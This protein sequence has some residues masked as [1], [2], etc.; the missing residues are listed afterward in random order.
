M[1][2]KRRT[3]RCC[4]VLPTWMLIFGAVWPAS[5]R[6]V[7][8]AGEID[9]F[10]TPPGHTAM[11][12]PAAVAVDSAGTVFVADGANDRVVVFN[13]AGQYI[14]EIRKVDEESLSR[15]VGIK[16]DPA[17]RLWI[18]DTGHGRVLVRGTDGRL[19]RLI[20]VPPADGGSL[21]DPTDVLP[22]PDDG[23][24]WVV[25]NDGHRLIYLDREGRH[26]AVVGE[27][28]EM[29]GRFH[30]P[31]MIELSQS[32]D[33][34][35]TE[36]LNSR[37]CVLNNKGQVVNVIGTY[38]ISIG[39]L[40]R[41]KG[42]ACD[43]QD[44]VWISDNLLG[45]VQ[46]FATDGRLIDVLRDS[47]GQP[48]PF[49]T[50]A[51]LAFD[52]LGRLYVVEV[53]PG[54]VRRLQIIEQD[55][56]GT[57]PTPPEP[58]FVPEQPRSC[59]VCHIE[60]LQP[61]APGSATALIKPSPDEAVEPVAGR[62]VMCLSC[63]DG[64]VADS[65]RLVWQEH[66]HRPGVEPPASMKVPA[67]LPL[68]NGRI[69]CRTCHSAHPAGQTDDMATA[70]SLRRAGA[71]NELCGACHIEKTGGPSAGVHPVQGMPWA[72]PEELLEP[73]ARQGPSPRDL[74]CRVCHMAHGSREDHLLVPGADTGQLCLNC[75]AKMRPGLWRSDTPREHPQA[76]PLSNDSQRQAIAAMGGR[77]GADGTITC[78]S[79][80]K[81]HDGVTD[82]YLLADSLTDSRLC[83]RCHPEQERMANSAH[84]LRQSAPSER[85][86]LGQTPAQ[87]GPCGPCH[88]IHQYA[89]RPDPQPA[90]PSGTCTT[91]HQ[92]GRCAEKVTRFPFGHP[93]ELTAD[94]D[95][96]G[97]LFT[98]SSTQPA[99][100]RRLVCATCHDPHRTDHGRFLVDQAD[101]ICGECHESH[102]AR[103]AGGHDFT[104]KPD[105]R[106]A[107]NRGPAETGKCVFCHAIHGTT[108]PLLWSATAKNPEKPDEMCLACHADEAQSAAKAAPVLQHPSGT[109]T[110]G[111][112][113]LADSR[114]P[115]YDDRCR[116]SPNGFVTCASCH[117][118][119]GD[120]RD[121]H[122][123]VRGDGPNKSP[124]ACLACHETARPI[125]STMHS[126]K[127]MQRHLIAA[128]DDRSARFCAPCHVVHDETLGPQVVDHS[129][130]MVDQF[131]SDTKLCLECHGAGGRSTLV[132]VTV[133]P[134]FHL[135]NM[136]ASEQPGFL[137][138]ADNQGRLRE[139]GQVTCQ[140][141]HLPHGRPAS[142]GLPPID[143]STATDPERRG[144][145]ALL[146]PYIVPN[147]CSSCHGT[148]GL[149]RFLYYHHPEKRPSLQV[150]VNGL[151][152]D[153]SEPAGDPS[154][155]R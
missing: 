16:T 31:F 59:T 8:V 47:R 43:S 69:S 113:A 19:D 17:G 53:Q 134:I 123:L 36:V 15:P 132:R 127:F 97:K 29:P 89:R 152:L 33:L 4:W 25:D 142:G 99:G 98:L 91:C 12:L 96:S 7:F 64:S 141:C 122:A 45:A 82:R 108:G 32:Q 63:H 77:L 52:R 128:N 74:T 105:L 79:C 137:P 13:P 106:N 5:A 155:R 70:V 21:A 26:I 124:T 37:A 84:D 61:P 101:R 144:L 66:G 6:T 133:H 125:E 49:D 115:L 78:L 153:T 119:H 46:I 129:A 54:R 50:P 86:R 3:S 83:T 95:S 145:K 139:E 102:F 104:G 154:V 147:L 135:R 68:V 88:S 48:M 34:L 87:S 150:N 117:D 148:E 93:L 40:Y 42:I 100:S 120:S 114:Y 65:R 44:R 111:K 27:Q 92:A 107:R 75:H 20:T 1:Q 112:V 2:L 85:N 14:A 136:V 39:Q 130:G 109:S 28:G 138:L 121:D 94:R 71:G 140:T 80:H 11:L 56:P 110:T 60:W 23:G 81:I 90:D 146:R 38:G 149:A 131:S 103:L 24:C 51:G 58:A 151:S 10:L 72:I 118:V 9:E 62:P 35:V 116:Q 76:P 22:L 126:Q 143:A 55:E 41:P 57:V 18:A 67:D 73:D 30:Y